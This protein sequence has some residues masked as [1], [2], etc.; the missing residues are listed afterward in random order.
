MIPEGWRKI[1]IGNFCKSL[2]PGRNKPKVFD[3]EIP[4]ITTP[5]IS[6]R[7]LPSRLQKNYVSPAAIKESGGRLVPANAVVITCVGDLGTTAITTEDVVL[8]Q[9]LHAF[10]PPKDTDVEYLAYQVSAQVP[11][12]MS[13]ASTTTIPYMNKGNCES[14]PILLPPLGEQREIAVIL[15]VA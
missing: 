15:G 14:I 4:W 5:E 11:Y 3:G 1:P 13:V 9:Q 12:M 7:Y 10:V 8:N 6:G 2:V